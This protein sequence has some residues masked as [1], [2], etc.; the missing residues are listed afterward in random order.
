M[1]KKTERNAKLL[2]L[3][4][5]LYS[6][7][8]AAFSELCQRFD[9]KPR[10]LLADLMTFNMVGIAPYTPLELTSIHFI[11]EAEVYDA[12]ETN[13]APDPNWSV[14][15][16]SEDIFVRPPSL[17]PEEVFVLLTAHSAIQ[18]SK[19]APD[20]AFDSAISKIKSAIE[21]RETSDT[22]ELNLEEISEQIFEPLQTAAQK[23]VQANVSY[24]SLRENQHLVSSVEPWKIYYAAGA[25]YMKAY[26]HTEGA[27][28]L[29]RL[30]RITS[31]ELTDSAFAQPVPENIEA[32]VYAPDP[33][34]PEIILELDP[35]ARWALDHFVATSLN[36]LPQNKVRATL[37]VSNPEFLEK[38]LLQIGKNGRIVS[39]HY[40]MDLQKQAAKKLIEKYY[41]D[42]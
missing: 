28:R 5:W 18:K 34:D 38:L 23:K 7:G 17:T 6:N 20:P 39:G 37:K 19:L 40:S 26:S 36:Y 12:Y 31:V 9:Y 4:P 21:T 29:F 33:D 10:D 1:A 27:E 14:Q 30:A 32:D 42:E 15:I 22:A 3:I 16:P 8:E 13:S 2:A 11:P 41:K 35:P 24:H 25:W